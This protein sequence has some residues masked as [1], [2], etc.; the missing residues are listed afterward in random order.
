MLSTIPHTPAAM[1]IA[2]DIR[3]IDLWL[4]VTIGLH[5]AD[6]VPGTR[7]YIE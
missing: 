2:A 1:S 5:R 7:R 3:G 6:T 4:S